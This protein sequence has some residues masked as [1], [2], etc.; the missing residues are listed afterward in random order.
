MSKCTALAELTLDGNE[1]TVLNGLNACQSLMLLS[2]SDND[3]EKV[4]GNALKTCGKLRELVLSRNALQANAL[5]S[6]APCAA[7]SENSACGTLSG[8]LSGTRVDQRDSGCCLATWVRVL[9]SARRRA[10]T[11]CARSFGRWTPRSTCGSSCG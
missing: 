2:A 9:A 8:T 1:L 5:A 4:P 7:W 10:C 11:S 3:I 6:F